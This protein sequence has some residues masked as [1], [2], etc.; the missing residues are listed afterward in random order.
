MYLKQIKQQLQYP[1]P[2]Q[3]HYDHRQV[4]QMTSMPCLYTCKE[5]PACSEN[6]KAVNKNTVSPNLS[7][8]L[9]KKY[10]PGEFVQ[11]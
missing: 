3:I 8:S 1:L 9:S 7:Q 6:W 4:E 2:F 10:E 11:L 5:F